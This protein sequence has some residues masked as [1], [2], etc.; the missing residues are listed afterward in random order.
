VTPALARERELAVDSGALVLQVTEGTP[1]DDAGIEVGDV[2]VEIGGEV[3]EGS[4]DV[5]TAIRS[6]RPGD[7]LTVVLNRDGER[8][9]VEAVLTERPA[10]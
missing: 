4:G 7:S 1:A 2:I 6:H 5:P 3:I 10:S 9:E 8:V